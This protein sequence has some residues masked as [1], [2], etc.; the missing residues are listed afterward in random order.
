MQTS[1]NVR[2]TVVCY[3]KMTS[4]TGACTETAQTFDLFKKTPAPAVWKSD[5]RS[6]NPKLQISK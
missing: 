4:F 6:I 2:P 5:V 1:A 3:D